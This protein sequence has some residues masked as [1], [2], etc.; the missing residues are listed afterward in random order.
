MKNLP[1]LLVPVAALCLLA[2][3][4]MDESVPGAE[5]VQDDPN[6]PPNNQPDPNNDPSPDQSPDPSADPSPDPIPDPTPE[7]DGAVS[8]YKDIKPIMDASCVGCHAQGGIGPFELKNYAQVAGLA[9]AVEAAVT[10]GAM[11]P[12]LPKE[13]CR[14]FKGERRLTQA[15]IDLIAQWVAEGL[16]EGDPSQDPGVQPES[17]ILEDPDLILKAAVPYT[18]SAERP[19]DYR[20]LVLD[21]DFNRDTYLSAYQI[22]PDQRAIVHHV[23]FYLVPPTEVARLGRLEAEDSAPGYECFGGPRAGD[24]LGTVAGWVPGS[25]PTHY[26]PGSAYIIPAG[27]KVVMQVHYNL[28]AGDPVPDRTEIHMRLLDE[29]PTEL[30]KIV[31]V[32]VPNL[33]IPADD[34][35]S[36][37]TATYPNPFG[38]TLRI[39]GTAP[40]MHML[41]TE[42][43]A[44]VNRAGGGR[45]CIVDIDEYDFNWQQFYEFDPSSTIDFNPGDT[46]S[47]ECVYDNSPENQPVVNGEQIEPRDVSWGDGSLDEMC[48]LYLITT[49]P[50]DGVPTCGLFDRCNDNCD[51]NDGACTLSCMSNGGGDCRQCS[52]FGMGECAS[53]RC[54]NQAQAMIP[55]LLGCLQAD[56][57]GV[58]FADS[59]PAQFDTLWGCLGPA[60]YDGQCNGQVSECGI[61]Q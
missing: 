11:P 61:A 26:P 50:F 29:P 57:V 51:P 45:D 41:G 43:R 21:H 54:G 39:V 17:L 16:N 32:P 42:I 40:H 22:V 48:L 37:H 13:G 4:C 1:F 19:D 47:L 25:V 44:R 10:S 52:I 53:N 20:C 27:S 60:F 56:D 49:E 9:P 34:P 8:Y 15:Q 33:E 24:L 18:A 58:C 28:L 12:W 3:A 59:C 46:V 23:L 35:N 2:C 14:E 31:P 7:V 36:T 55:C 38:K 6:N 5:G 30:V